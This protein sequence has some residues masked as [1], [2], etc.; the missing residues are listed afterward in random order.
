MRFEQ[1]D[2]RLLLAAGDLRIV[3]YNVRGFS[4]ATSSDLGTVLQ[5][6][7]TNVHN[8]VSRPIDVLTLQEVRSQSTTTANVVSQLNAIYGD[9]AYAR[10]SLN[11]QATSSNETVGLVY[12]TQTI[13]LI[14]EVGIGTPSASGAARQTLRYLLRPLEVGIG[15]DFYVYNSHYKA[16]NDPI[17]EGRRQVEAQAIRA[18]AD[19][20]GQ[21]TLIVYA[22]DFNVYSGFEPAFQTLLASGNG[23]A[24]DPLNRVGD[25]RNN[26]NFRDVFTQAPLVNPPQGSGLAGGGLDDRFDFQ[27]LT[28]EWFDGVGLE[29]RPGSYRAFGNNGTVPVNNSINISANTALADL[30]NR[31]TILNLLTTV[32]DHLPVVVDYQYIVPNSPPTNVLLTSSSIE[33]NRAPGS[34]VGTFSTIDA[35]ANDTFTYSLVSGTG[36]TN[37]AS[38]SIV[39]NQLR[40]ASSFNFE[41]KSSYSMRVRTT[42]QSNAS[43]ERVFTIQILDVNEAPT[44]LSL[45]NAFIAENLAA[46]TL[47]GLLSAVDPDANSSFTFSLVSGS[48]DS[49]NGRFSIIGNQLFAVNSFDFEAKSSYSIRTRVVDQ[50]GLGLDRMFAIGVLDVNEAPIAIPGGP[51]LATQ[52]QVFNLSG[53]G[54]DPDA[55]QTL[56]YEWDLD[57]DG[58]RFDV[59]A[60]GRTPT[61]TYSAFGSYTIALRVI[62]NGTPSLSSISTTSVAVVGPPPKI[63]GVVFG[64]GTA[65]RSMIRSIDVNFDS[66]VSFAPDTFA[67]ERRVNGNFVAIPPSEL[68]I[69]ASNLGGATATTA[70]LT[71]SG[72]SVINGSLS[73]GHYRLTIF[74]DRIQGNGTNLDG[75]NDDQAGGNFVRGGIEADDFFRLYG[76]TNGDRLVGIAEFGQFRASFGKVPN[77]IGYNDAFDYDGNGVGISDFGQFRARFGR[78]K[79]PW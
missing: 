5:A 77:A 17:S 40:T 50:G 60:L 71:F 62:D 47:V 13:Q 61:V 7:G 67:L 11:G 12:N 31:T 57:Y 3:S 22:G 75:D 48:G 37:N 73:D 43:F 4:G 34:I 18:N 70:R 35:N 41:A 32:T 24:F 46:P 23:Q 10:G 49:D 69:G 19:A 14:S 79:L 74:G 78:P 39:G 8:G 66:I 20:L 16:S 72:T 53:N 64:D 36:S 54:I 52:S 63:N 25:W 6:I 33:E 29:Y 26:N 28:G 38:F 30:P 44:S 55:G 21:G 27:L 15:N 2:L 59:D 76:D 42:D 45:S 51:Y 65:K 9:G 1:L 58:I 56:S 68:A